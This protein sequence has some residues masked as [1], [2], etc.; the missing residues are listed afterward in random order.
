MKMEGTTMRI[1]ESNRVIDATGATTANF[2]PMAETIYRNLPNEVYHASRPEKEFSSTRLK[3]LAISPAH[4]DSYKAKDSAACDL[5]NLYHHLCQMAIEGTDP[6]T[7][8]LVIPDFKMNTNADLISQ[9]EWLENALGLPA[10]DTAAMKQADLKKH[11]ETLKG[12][13]APRTA[14]AK[15]KY[16]LAT[17][18]RDAFL[19]HPTI[20]SIL[21]S[22][23]KACELSFFTKFVSGTESVMI[24][25]R[26]DLLL[27]TEE[28]VMI[29]DWKGIGKAATDRHLAYQVKDYRYDLSVAMYSDVV[30]KFTEKPV[31][32]ALA[33]T[34][35][36]TPMP[37]KTRVVFLD[38]ETIGRAHD[39]YAGRLINWLDLR[40]S[41][42]W[43]GFHLSDGV[44]ILRIPTDRNFVEVVED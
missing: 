20:A 3:A 44:E 27:E 22:A 30:A 15:D 23:E 28:A 9:I 13:V 34:E 33:F 4:E 8:Y 36:E 17:G 25:T 11:I 14:V 1:L 43:R 12:S 29:L 39:E 24:K 16:D 40:K 10:S 41:G 31:H 7:R 38:A 21:E 18:I 32:F 5:G 6:A 42:G 19:S 35:T 26:T 2:T 37:E